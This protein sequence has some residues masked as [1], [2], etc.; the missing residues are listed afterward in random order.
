MIQGVILGTHT[1]ECAKK[2]GQEIAKNGAVKKL[3][4]QM[5]RFREE[6]AGFKENVRIFAPS[7]AM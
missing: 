6:V 2:M 3:N 1:I 4:E 7:I 5:R